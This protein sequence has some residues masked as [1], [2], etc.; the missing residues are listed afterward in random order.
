M[1][2]I[3]S[4]KIEDDYVLVKYNDIQNKIKKTR[5]KKFHSKLVYMKNT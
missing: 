3:M 4:F 5:D 2:E 1:V